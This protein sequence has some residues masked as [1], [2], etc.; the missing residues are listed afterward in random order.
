[1]DNGFSNRSKATKAWLVE[2][3]RFVVH[4]TPAAAS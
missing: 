1:M 4:H 2:H 3:P